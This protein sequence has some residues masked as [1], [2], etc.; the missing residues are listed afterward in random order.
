MK[1]TDY[2]WSHQLQ[3]HIKRKDQ[4]STVLAIVSDCVV[5]RNQIHNSSLLILTHLESSVIYW[6]VEQQYGGQNCKKFI[7]SLLKTSSPSQ[8]NQKRHINNNKLYLYNTFLKTGLLSP[9]QT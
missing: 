4:K 1:F 7:S 6:I 8:R 5:E 3:A 2:S 9:S